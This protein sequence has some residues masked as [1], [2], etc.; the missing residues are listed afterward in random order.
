MNKSDLIDATAKSAGLT[1]AQ[2]I[3][4]VN[5]LLESIGE[6]LAKGETVS[7]LGFGTFGIT[8][9]GARVGRNPRT[10]ESLKI[11]AKQSPSFKAGKALKDQVNK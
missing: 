2:A 6:A 9:R 1:K 5:G 3:S 4:A 8:K 10:G 7:I 11:A